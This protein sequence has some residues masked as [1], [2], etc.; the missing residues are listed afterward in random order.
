MLKVFI[1]FKVFISFIKVSI[2]S[3][4]FLNVKKFII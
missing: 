4:Q 3:V 1:V 2:I